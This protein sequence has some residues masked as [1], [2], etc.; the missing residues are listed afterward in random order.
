M[1]ALANEV[2]GGGD[3]AIL[4]LCSHELLGIA[5]KGDFRIHI[6]FDAAL[7]KRDS[8]SFAKNFGH[9]LCDFHCVLDFN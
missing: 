7:I 4:N 3:V 6:P 2:R 1:G 8:V 5:T 9:I